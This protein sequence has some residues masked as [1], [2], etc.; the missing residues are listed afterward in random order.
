MKRREPSKTNRCCS[1][2]F[3]GKRASSCSA[4]FTLIELLVVI[5]IIGILS[6]IALPSFL[7]YVGFSRLSKVMV[8]IE[9]L[10]K[11]CKISSMSG[12]VCTFSLSKPGEPSAVFIKKGNSPTQSYLLSDKFD[13][14]AAS[15]YGENISFEDGYVKDRG[16]ILGGNDFT[17][18][19]IKIN[20]VSTGITIGCI[21]TY[22]AD[23]HKKRGKR[24]ADC[25]D[26]PNPDFNEDLYIPFSAKV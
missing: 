22:S 26:K 10:H 1:F 24:L 11:E 23:G 25:P 20:K 19:T 12:P 7:K 21:V 2:F 3:M 5:A 8:E 15:F 18:H 13:V 4:G 9:E 16:G 14:F 6:S 17:P